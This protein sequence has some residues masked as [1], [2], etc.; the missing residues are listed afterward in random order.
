ME[1]NKG[2]KS[3]K[4]GYDKSKNNKK[5]KTTQV[6]HNNV[7]K[8]N[9]AAVKDLEKVKLYDNSKDVN[10]E[11]YEDFDKFNFIE[12]TSVLNLSEIITED[13]I[14]E[15]YGDVPVMVPAEETVSEEVEPIFAE[16]VATEEYLPIEETPVEEVKEEITEVKEEEKVEEIKEE[17]KKDDKKDK[18]KKKPINIGIIFLIVFIGVIAFVYIFLGQPILN[19]TA[20]EGGERFSI[21]FSKLEELKADKEQEEF[22]DKEVTYY[23]FE[24]GI[25]KSTKGAYLLRNGNSVSFQYGDDAQIYNADIKESDK[26]YYVYEEERIPFISEYFEYTDSSNRKIKVEMGTSGLE[27]T[28]DSANYNYLSLEKELMNYEGIYRNGNKYILVYNLYDFADRLNQNRILYYDGVNYG[29]MN[30]IELF[31]TNGNG[32]FDD[33]TVDNVTTFNGKLAEGSNNTYKI[34]IIK[35]NNTFDINFEYNLVDT[36]TN[37]NYNNLVGNYIK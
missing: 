19:F 5:K 10:L 12:N 9:K 8:V 37:V 30:T 27:V 32:K 36:N 15:D 7:K 25:Y 33:V 3:Y 16:E 6:R 29:E 1:N 18:S 11:G 13:D 22:D 31:D 34:N 20:D 4:V 2:K 35:N 17:V 21:T 14:T 24:N 26:D 28:I 23:K